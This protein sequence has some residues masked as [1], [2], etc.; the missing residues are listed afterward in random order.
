MNQKIK[1]EFSEESKEGGGA[2]FDLE[3]QKSGSRETAINN[4]N[5]KGKHASATENRRLVWKYIVW[6]L[7]LQVNRQYFTLQEYRT[8]RDELISIYDIQPS[9][10]L[11]GGLTSLVEKGILMKNKNLYSIDYKL[12]G[13]MRK[14]DN[15]EYGLAVKKMYA[16]G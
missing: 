8:K 9:S 7:L 12:V 4:N 10:R 11:S 3:E 5:N 14:K 6:P 2:V 13:H 15:L 1:M 16:K